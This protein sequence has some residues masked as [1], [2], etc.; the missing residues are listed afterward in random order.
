[1]YTNILGPSNKKSRTRTTG[2]LGKELGD[3]G[4]PI[5]GTRGSGRLKTEPS[6]LPSTFHLLPPVLLPSPILLGG[7]RQTEKTLRSEVSYT[8]RINIVVSTGAHIPITIR[9]PM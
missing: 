2:R 3:Q 7:I 4:L 8:G 1:M 6:Q 9:H 5:K